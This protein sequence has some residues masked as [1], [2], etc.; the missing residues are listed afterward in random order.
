MNSGERIR[1]PDRLAAGEAYLDYGPAIP[2]RYGIS[3][4]RALVRDPRSVFV[5]WEWPAPV[6]GRAW[7]VRLRDVDA[8]SATVVQLDR[9][10]AGLGSKYFEASPDRSYEAD[11]GWTD[12]SAFHAVMTSNRVRT[13]REGPSAEVDPEWMP[14]PGEREILGVLAVPPP[15][16]YGRSG[17]SHA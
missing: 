12:G 8:G 5:Y 17:P 15:R 7:A 11:L 16:G 9:T 6:E 2:D 13:P 1:P 4:V 10:G 3:T 14:G